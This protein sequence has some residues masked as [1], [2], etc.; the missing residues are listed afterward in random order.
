MESGSTPFKPGGLKA[1]TVSGNLVPNFAKIP[2]QA[3]D[4]EEMVL[5]E[6]LLNKDAIFE[7]M[8]FLRP[9]M[10]YKEAHKHIYSAMLAL[11]NRHDP[12]DI[13][14]VNMELR[15]KGHNEIVGG[16]MYLT[17]LTN[18][19]SSGGNLVTHAR[20]VQEMAIKRQL[21]HVSGDIT[22]K[23][24]EDTSDV[25]EL[26]DESEQKMFEILDSNIKRNYLP[27]NEVLKQALE[28]LE[29][30]KNQTDGLT[31][32]P[33]GFS[34]LDQMTAGWQKGAL[35]II[36]ARPGMGKTAF[37]LSASRNAAIDFQK[38]VAIFSLEMPAVDLTMRLISSEASIESEKL[39]TGKLENHEWA[40]LTTKAGSLSSAPI[41]ID[42]TS[43][44]NVLELRAKCRRLKS[45]NK[46]DLVIIDYLQLMSGGNPNMQKG[47]N[48]EQEIAYISRSLK[49]MAKELDVPV[50]ALSQLSRD[51]E[52]R[53]G[54][55]TPQLSDLRESGSLEQ[56]ADMVIFLYR[57]EYYGI[58]ADEG[59]NS[60]QGVG[61]VIIGKHRAGSTGTVNLRF[62]GKYTRFSD[63]DDFDTNFGNFGG[64][65]GG[66]AAGGG[67]GFKPLGGGFGGGEDFGGGAASGGFRSQGIPS[68]FGN[69][70]TNSG[71]MIVKSGLKNR[72]QE[73]GGQPPI[74]PVDNVPF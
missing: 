58:L 22:N 47:G 32:V 67:G 14:T 48:R 57:P 53:G 19:V 61:Q 11:V 40:Q 9:D 24:F 39:R 7:V 49:Q 31:G 73:G 34:A 64:G 52:K 72:G 27:I 42:D 21:I 2:P 70:G 33:S 15:R 29:K 46:L 25:F 28:D 8:E 56:D 30:R 12:I 37:V 43:A 35:I 45:Q 41:F 60:L 4:L 13:M 6:V 51:V 68:E 54:D 44:L 38:S 5:G 59:G 1:R 66:P 63:M 74:N 62:I 50:I 18:R 10:F 17:G 26:L 20:Y 36:A 55:K 23:A 71:S 3:V 69:P 16:M 65:F